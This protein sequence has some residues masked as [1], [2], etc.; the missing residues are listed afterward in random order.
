MRSSALDTRAGPGRSEPFPVLATLVLV[1]VGI[2]AFAAFLVLGAFAPDRERDLRGGSALSDSAIGFAGVVE[3]LR[4]EGVPVRI[5]RVAEGGR[6]GL[7][8]LTP[9]A[10]GTP[11]PPDRLANRGGTILVVLPKWLAAPLAG[12]SGWVE[13]AGPVA[14]AVLEHLMP[15][16]ID[17]VR[18]DGTQNAV[19]HGGT[20]TMEGLRALP[21]GAVDRLQSVGSSADWTPVLLDA[22]GRPLL[23]RWTG[24][25][26]YMLSDPDV[27]DTHGL[28]SVETAR[29]ALA[30]IDALRDRGPVTFDVTLDGFGA[31]PSLLRLLFEPPVLGATLCAAATGLLI[32][33]MAANRFGPVREPDRIHDFG[34]RAL[35]DNSAGLIAMARREPRMARPY[36]QIVRGLAARALGV[37][38]QLDARALDR[39]LDAASHAHGAADDWTTLDAVAYGVRR[40]A[41]LMAFAARLERW[42][43]EMMRDHH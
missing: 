38:P 39:W 14:P 18:Q 29:T 16:P 27:L 3:L 15:V 42:R 17:V 32:V 23:L 19:L 10:S 35:A 7:L 21:I 6:L 43:S 24:H 34:K 41:D 12:H 31:P 36:A 37:P 9:P 20:G 25:R 33:L 1:A 11:I 26:V 30:L 22:A 13:T 5:S 4:A 40:R 8:V 2:A 28:R